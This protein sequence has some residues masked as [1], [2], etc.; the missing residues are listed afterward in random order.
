MSFKEHPD[1]E[2]RH[3]KDY[4]DKRQVPRS[5]PVFSLPIYDVDDPTTEGRV[6]DVTELG[7]R[8]GGLECVVGRRKTF[9]IQVEELG[10]LKPFSFDAECRWVRIDPDTGEY[11][12]G[13][14]I[15]GISPDDLQQ[16]RKIIQSLSLTDSD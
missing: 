16:L 7:I 5:Y 6:L 10:S 3:T 12:A 8:I 15:T 11:I 2:D 1:E 4:R 14:E 13:F 9:L